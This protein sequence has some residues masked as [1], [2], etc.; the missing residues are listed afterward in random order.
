MDIKNRAILIG[1]NINNQIDFKESM[2]ELKELVLAC[3]LE[4]AGQL[5]QNLAR[6]NSK[7]HIGSGKVKEAEELIFDKG[8][9]V[10]VFNNELSPSQLRNLEKV[11][12]CQII[13][14]TALILEIF[15]RRAKTKE[16][17]L[18]VE[19][20]RLQYMLPRLIGGSESL[21]QQV[22]GG[23][24]TR[25]AGEKKLELDRRRI[26][27]RISKLKD[28]LKSISKE[29]QNQRKR[30]IEENLPNVALVGYTNAGKSTLMNTMIELFE[31]TSKNKVLEKDMLFATLKTSV[32]N[33]TLPDNKSFLLSDT[34]G[35]VSDLPHNLIK[36]FRSTLQEV[37]E[38]D[39]LLHVIDLSNPNYEQQIEVTK[40]TLKEIG[41]RDVP[42]IYV[43]NKADLTGED[44]PLVI[45]DRVYIS[46]SKRI[47]IDEL[48]ELMGKEI[49]RDYVQCQ[50]LIPYEEGSL[51]SYFNENANVKEMSHEYNG[52]LLTLEC[53][54]SD[55]KRYQE[56]VY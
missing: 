1:V 55:Y 52:T 48:I 22:G 5:E 33:I 39:L 21:S 46:A 47:G 29:R 4:V 44:F 35:F 23:A 6:I 54:E 27:K 42:M 16:A 9:D 24:I 19:L 26:Q 41:A 36:A 15:A 45:D 30:R 12:D 32:R 14:R 31:E 10:V 37:R 49:F 34:V 51:I 25:G 11:L 18:Q 56:F 7:Y 13:D 20:A 28:E 43:Y 2:E 17:K 8:A 3:E 40:K 50:M 53:K 38:A